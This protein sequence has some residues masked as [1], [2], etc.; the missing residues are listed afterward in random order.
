[1]P[2]VPDGILNLALSAAAL[3]ADPD[4]TRIDNVD[5]V[6]VTKIH[7]ERGRPDERSKTGIGTATV[8]GTDKSGALDPTNPTSPFWDLGAGATTLNPT[9][10]A[11]VGFWN[12]VDAV[13]DG[14]FRGHVADW[15]YTRQQDGYFTWQLDL[16]DALD[17][18]E[19]AQM[20]PD[21]AGD[22][23]PPADVSSG[24][25]YYQA[26]TVQDRI[27][28]LVADGAAFTGGTWPADLL[29]IFTG[30]VYVQ[31][32][33]YAAA[34]PIRQGLDEACDAE[35]PGVANRYVSKI[36]I[37]TFHGRYARFNPADVSY[38]IQT[39]K[40]GDI[41]AY[42]DDDTT[43]VFNGFE[44][45]RGKTN[46]VNAATAYPKGITP[47][48]IAAQFVADGGS[49]G[50]YAPRSIAFENLITGEDATTHT[51][52]DGNTAA[53]ETKGYGQY[54][55]DNYALPRNRISKVTFRTP[56]TSRSTYL[57][58][59]LGGVEL[60]D[61]LSVTT[62]HPGGGGFDAEGVFV[63]RLTYD[64]V[65]LGIDPDSGEPLC[66]VT[67]EVDT[68]PQAYYDTDPFPPV[69]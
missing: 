59:L 35:F 48:Q 13:W 58:R 15:T 66:D 46:L 2:T 36:G 32:T 62:T 67:L 21:Q 37:L 1:M 3:E 16:V 26:A 65:P 53:Q 34:T 40:V 9:K 63:E 47:K 42:L 8:Y 64:L 60:N 57:W 27:Y 19:D 31:G 23:S 28:A 12:P 54:W 38:G 14:L 44:F 10:Q 22:G 6:T 69:S 49:V 43:S 20:V 7:I 50:E 51:N 17:I 39:W 33:S 25:V 45:T 24:S 11:S 61:I 30:N 4:W 52:P 68:S 56:P 55:V 5:G 41:A 29:Q 18:L